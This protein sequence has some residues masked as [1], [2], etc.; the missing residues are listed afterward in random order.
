VANRKFFWIGAA[1]LGFLVMGST[2]G[3]VEVPQ[4]GFPKPEDWKAILEVALIAGPLAGVFI[5]HYIRRDRQAE[6][7]LLAINRLLRR[8]YGS[9]GIESSAS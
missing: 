6:L 1:L 5:R 2:Y 9:S 3:L 7:T 4:H 8:N